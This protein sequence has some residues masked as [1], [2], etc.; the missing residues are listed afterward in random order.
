MVI[1]YL[2]TNPT[3]STQQSLLALGVAPSLLPLLAASWLIQS[4]ASN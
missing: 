1:S 3:A 4:V 2:A